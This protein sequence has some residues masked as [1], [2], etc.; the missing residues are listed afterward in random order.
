MIGRTVITK[1]VAFTL[2]TVLGVGYVLVHYIGAG[3][4]L[5]G[6]SYTAYVDLPDSGGIFTTASVTYRGVE[7]GRVGQIALRDDGIRVALDMNSS[8]HV[9]SDVRAVIGNGSALGEQYVDLQPA[10]TGGPYLREGSVIPADHTSL[11]VSTETL[12]V[13]L[14]T[15]IKSVPNQDL[16]TLVDELG[17]GFAETGPALR[18]LLDATTSLSAEANLDAPDTV[19]LLEQGRTVLDTQNDLSNDTVAFA[20][21]LAAFSSALKG[22]DAD[23]R[24][25]LSAGIGAAA[26]VDALEKSVDATLPITLGNLVSLGQVTA[27]RIPAVRQVLIVYPYIVATSFGLFPGDGTTRFGVPVPPSEESQPCTLGYVPPEKRRLPSEL[28]YP[29]IRYGAYCKEPSSSSVGPRGAR[30]AP[31]PG[32]GRLADQPSYK[33]NEGLPSASPSP[34]AA[35]SSFDGPAAGT[36]L[37]ATTL[38]GPGTGDYVLATTGGQREPGGDSSWRALILGPLR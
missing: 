23:L 7:I 22:S 8:P 37:P 36:S 13:N 32:G 16:H 10:T 14:D 33:N 38:S 31:E 1:L 11:P 18:R 21:H 26:Q 29:P 15:L 9:P 3:R 12:L 5:L 34:G 4:A 20:K 6:Q 17:T 30:Q 25:V 2:V 35:P 27:V 19:G 28:A 24:R